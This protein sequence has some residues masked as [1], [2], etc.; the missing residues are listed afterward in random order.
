[1]TLT[2]KIHKAADGKWWYAPLTLVSYWLLGALG[3]C[4]TGSMIVAERFDYLWRST[5]LFAGGDQ[6]I[7][8]HN[9]PI[10]FVLLVILFAS[11]GPIFFLMGW[12]KFVSRRRSY[13]A[14][15]KYL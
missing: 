10:G 4:V 12:V 1:M 13:L 14:N 15:A 11:S 5:R 9:H 2:E 8:F 6:V 7:T 3:L